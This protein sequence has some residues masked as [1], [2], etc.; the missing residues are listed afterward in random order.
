MD[1]PAAKE[2]PATDFNKLDLSQLQSFSFGTQWT[3]DKSD[4]AGRAGSHGRREDRPPRGGDDRRPGPREGEPRRDRRAFLKPAVT[5]APAG[6]PAGGESHAPNDRQPLRRDPRDSRGG[7][8]GPRQYPPRG[9]QEQPRP[10]YESPFFNVAFYPEDTSFAA[11]AKTIRAS[12]RTLELFDIARTILAKNDRFVAVVQRKPAADAS[13]K[14]VPLYL[15]V[16]DGLPFETEDAVLAHVLTKHLDKFFELAQVEIDPPKGNF[17]VINRCTITGELL[18]PPNY[19]RYSQIIQQH[20][21]AHAARM[22]FEKFRERIESVRDPELINQWLEKMKKATRYTWKLAN[23]ADAATKPVVPVAESSGL[24]PET[25]GLEIPATQSSPAPETPLAE[26]PKAAESSD[27]KPQASGSESPAAQPSSAASPAIA[28]DTIE[29]ARAHLVANAPEK[30][31]RAVD[32]MRFQGKFLETLPPGEI[33]RAV[34]GHLERQR[35]FPLDTA[36]GLRGRLRRES[37][38]IFKKGSKGV[39]YVCAVKRRFRVPGQVF[40]ESIGTLIAFIEGRPMV[41]ASELPEKFL[42]LAPIA[43]LQPAP[44]GAQPAET[45]AIPAPAL[46]PE[47][48]EK[49]A[50]LQGDLRWLVTEGYVTEFIDGRLFAPPAIAEAKKKEAEASENDPEN[51]PDAPASAETETSTH[52]SNGKSEPE[53]A[54]AEP[55]AVVAEVPP[56]EQAQSETPLG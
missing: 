40:A 6:A 17:Q 11:L 53:T 39:S 42:G 51:F 18:G 20:H 2:N 10:P 25:P 34:E 22:P 46:T 27:P 36:N 49:L 23:P 9:A 29:E 21:A 4:P 28:F 15:S 43:S 30:A 56:V 26:T 19:H 12:C 47:Q 8:A 16:P 7:P 13:T 37:F 35:R 44:A 3:Q 45:P 54:P 5:G 24:K 14:P 33:R 32:P 48:R 38:T 55:A 41:R 50:R 1:D 31:F 52:K